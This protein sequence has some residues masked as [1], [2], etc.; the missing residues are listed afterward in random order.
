MSPGQLSDEHA[1]GINLLADVA[2]RRIDLTPVFS[3]A[4]GMPLTFCDHYPH[5]V[6]LK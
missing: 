6:G 4:L 1:V 2:R 5:L 3:S